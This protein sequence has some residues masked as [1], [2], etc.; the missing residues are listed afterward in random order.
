MWVLDILKYWNKRKE[1]GWEKGSPSFASQYQ[2]SSMFLVCSITIDPLPEVKRSKL[3]ARSMFFWWVFPGTK[4]WPKEIAKVSGLVQSCNSQSCISQLSLMLLIKQHFPRTRTP[5]SKFIFDIPQPS[6]QFQGR[7]G[8]CRF[9]FPRSL[10]RPFSNVFDGL[11]S[12][13]DGTNKQG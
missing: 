3:M 11:F 9:I 2:G 4:Y 12:L 1:N 6:C 13:K 7:S 10:W 8:R 5:T